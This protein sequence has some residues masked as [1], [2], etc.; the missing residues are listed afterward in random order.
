MLPNATP[1][2]LP[3]P[4]LVNIPTVQKFSSSAV[5]NYYPSSFVIF[6]YTGYFPHPW[7]V[8]GALFSLLY[9]LLTLPRSI[10]Y[11]I[12]QNTLGYGFLYLFSSNIFIN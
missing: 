5:L 4:L 3:S 11:Y 2:S 6:S 8:F 10:S 7:G 1:K 12:P 9:Q